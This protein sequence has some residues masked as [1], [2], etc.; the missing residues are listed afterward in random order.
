LS[1]ARTT[2]KQNKP[3]TKIIFKLF[4]VFLQSLE[5]LIFCFLLAQCGLKSPMVVSC[6]PIV[7]VG[8]SNQLKK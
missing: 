4:V 8:I 6:G 2:G 3:F 7:V 1:G 5:V